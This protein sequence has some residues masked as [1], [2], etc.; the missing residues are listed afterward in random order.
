MNYLVCVLLRHLRLFLKRRIW[1]CGNGTRPVLQLLILH[2]CL[3]FLSFST[4]FF[5]R[6]LV[7]NGHSTEFTIPC[8]KKGVDHL[9]KSVL[10]KINS[11]QILVYFIP[12]HLEYSFNIL[13]FVHSVNFEYLPYVI[14]FAPRWIKHSLTQRASLI[15][16]FWG[17]SSLQNFFLPS[18]ISSSSQMF[19]WFY[20]LL[21]WHKICPQ[22]PWPYIK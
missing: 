20:L 6:D 7:I 16:F 17:I 15:F 5:E 11:Y 19:N 10:Q 2:F 9:F 18:H 14:Y 3:N 21:T 22:Y 1:C 12:H 4:L 13:V 8:N